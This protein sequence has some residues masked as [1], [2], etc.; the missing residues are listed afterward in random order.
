MLKYKKDCKGTF[1]VYLMII[2]NLYLSTILTPTQGKR[3]QGCM[4]Q[5][6]F[7]SR[8]LLQSIAISLIDFFYFESILLKVT[9]IHSFTYLSFLFIL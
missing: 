7:L 3:K 4:E 1:V 9:F 2:L 5:L 6:P 8:L